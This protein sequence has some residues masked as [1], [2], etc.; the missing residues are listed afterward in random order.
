MRRRTRAE[1]RGDWKRHRPPQ[2]WDETFA[3]HSGALLKPGRSDGISQANPQLS[4][5]YSRLRIASRR[6]AFAPLSVFHP[7]PAFEPDSAASSSLHDGHRLAK[8]GFP[9]FNSNSSPQ[10]AQT[11]IGNVIRLRHQ[12]SVWNC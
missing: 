4:L 9:G 6:A 8:P 3:D 5:R 10:T 2:D 7:S 1:I 11:L 12:D